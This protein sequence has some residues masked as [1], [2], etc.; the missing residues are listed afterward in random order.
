LTLDTYTLV[1]SSVKGIYSSAEIPID[2][3]IDELTTIL[4]NILNIEQVIVSKLINKIRRVTFISGV[5][6][7]TGFTLNTSN[8]MEK[9]NKYV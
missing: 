1:V 7:I 4:Q 8:I 2:S 6:N 3:S 9:K 5:G